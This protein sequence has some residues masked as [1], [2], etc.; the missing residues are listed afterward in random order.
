MDFCFNHRM[1]PSNTWF[2]KPVPQLA[3]Y[4]G[5]TTQSF[6]LTRTNVS[7]H[8]QLDYML[9]NDKWKNSITNVVN[10]HETLLDS[11]HA[12]ILADM[13][14][15]FASRNK[16]KDSFHGSHTPKFRTPNEEQRRH[17]NL[18]VQQGITEAKQNGSWTA[19]SSF[20]TLARILLSAGKSSL[21]SFSSRQKKDY[22]SEQTWQKIE[23][24][25][26]AINNGHWYTAKQLTRD[27]RRLARNDKETSLLQ[28]LDA[29]TQDGYQWEGLKKMR[30]PFQP[31][32]FKYKNKNGEIINE[33]DFAEAAAEYFAEVQWAMPQDDQIDPSK[34]NSPLIDGNS[35][36]VD[37]SFS[38]DELHD[39]LRL[40][41]N[42]KAPGPDG[43]RSELVKWLSDENR[44]HLL[45][46][47][48]NIL[49]SGLYPDCF[50]LANIATCFK[51]GDATE[52]KNYRPIALLQVFYKILARLVRNRFQLAYDPWIQ[53]TQYGFRP[54]KSTSQ[55]I[56]LARRLLDISERQGSNLSDIVGLGEGF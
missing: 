4:R 17:Y 38:I 20:E 42:Q 15:K 10:I 46:L 30:K 6:D 54:K 45:E 7:T 25:Q 35:T 18:L 16:P 2:Q 48:N 49:T 34:E 31:K 11:D 43:C 56:F 12:L 24:K 1:I 41:K 28:E 14:V 3:T 19:S 53:S 51:K 26:Q 32:R 37:S 22:L 36:M 27:I 8:A 13:H 23:A 55:A 33:K 39:V 40:L 9:I 5:T 29:I 21:P 50:K 44:L 47:F 52:M